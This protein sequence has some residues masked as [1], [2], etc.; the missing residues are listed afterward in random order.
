MRSLLLS[1]APALALLV[2][3]AMLGSPGY[4]AAQ[5][6]NHPNEIWG[7]LHTRKEVQPIFLKT[8]QSMSAKSTVTRW[9]RS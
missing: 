7:S 6:S 3:F 4:A 1:S 8:L 2:I 9:D 5:S